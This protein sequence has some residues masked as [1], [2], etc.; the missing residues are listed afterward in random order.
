M[1]F[2]DIVI[3][4]VERL[5]AI[6]KKAIHRLIKERVERWL[7]SRVQ[8]ESGKAEKVYL[9]GKLGKTFP[10]IHISYIPQVYFENKSFFVNVE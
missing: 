1:N 10:C 2:L 6:M 5:P 4:I 9:A 3:M 7:A 8:I